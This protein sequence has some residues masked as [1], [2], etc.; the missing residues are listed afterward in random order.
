MTVSSLFVNP[1]QFNRPDDFTLYP[2]TLDA[3]LQLMEASGV[4]FCLLPTEQEMYADGYRYQVQENHL[5]QLMEGT[6]RPGHFNGVL[7][8]VM[9]LFLLTR[10]NRAYYGEKRLS[11][12]CAS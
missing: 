4:D 11:T 8:V 6:H 10:P 5:C 12:I 7:T 9:K 2:R 3:D 1:T